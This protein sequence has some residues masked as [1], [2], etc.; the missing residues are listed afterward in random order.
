VQTL[1]IKVKTDDS[2]DVEEVHNHAFDLWKAQEQQVLSYFLTLVSRD[3]LV[4]ITVLPTAVEVWKHLETSFASQ[5]CARVINTR[6]TLAT[7][8]KGSS[9]TIEYFAKMKSLADEMASVAKKLDDEELTSYI[10]AGLDVEYNSLVSSIAARVEP[11]TFKELYSQLLAYENRL[12]LRKE[13]QSF[14]SM[15]NASRGRGTFSKGRSGRSPRGGGN[16]GGRG[17]GDFSNKARNKFP[18][19][20]LCGNTNH[21]V[22]K[23]YKRFDPN[24]MG[25]ERS[26]NVANS[27]GVD[28]NWYADLGATYHVTRELDKL[29]VR[30]T[31][32]GNDQI[33]AANGTGMCIKHVGQSIICTPNHNLFL[34]NV[35]HVP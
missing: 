25:E 8:L 12:E 13:G 16:N 35:L 9:T 18:P 7:T 14:S 24:F 23:C 17:C 27:Y 31:Y 28:S 3:V 32:N 2:K 21:L 33:Y 10:L 26:A 22:F 19:C 15:N 20:Q 29:T 34:N 30:D 5:S 1:K 6:M 4:Q 11:I